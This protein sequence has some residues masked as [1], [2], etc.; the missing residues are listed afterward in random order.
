M[1]YARVHDQTVADDYYAAMQQVER[2]LDLSGAPEN[3]VIPLAENER[4]QLLGLA[5]ELAKPVLSAK[6]RLKIVA[7]MRHLLTTQP[8]WPVPNPSGYAIE[9]NTP[10]GAAI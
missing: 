5:E 1:I 6:T 8:S 3:A 2:Q 4:E 9:L 7:Q 10:Q